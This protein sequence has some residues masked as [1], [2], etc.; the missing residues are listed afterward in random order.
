MKSK[1]WKATALVGLVLATPHGLAVAQES[2]ARAAEEAQKAE[3]LA[4]REREL[5]REIEREAAR[6][7]REAEGARVDV[8]VEMREAESRL[9]EA[10]RRVAALSTERLR[11]GRWATSFGNRP[12]LGVNIDS[13][14]SSDEP[15]AGVQI[16]SVSPGGAAAEAG[17]RGG[18]TMTAINGEPLSA[19]SGKAA[20]ARL[21]EFMKGVE[22]GD[23]LDVEYLRNG[24]SATV[25][26]APRSA[27]RVFTFRSGPPAMGVPDVM[28]A[29]TAPMAL[30]VAGW[31]SGNGFGSLEM[32]SLTEELGRYFGAE[33]GM[34]VVRAPKD[35][36]T[37]KLRDGDVIL[38]IDGR[39][40]RSVSHAARIL[41]SY[42]A[43]EVVEIRILRDQ[44]RQTVEVEIPDNRTGALG[45][46]A[47]PAAP[48]AVIA[49][50]VVIDSLVE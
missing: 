44:R 15:V 47:A 16:T 41:Y 7:A 1:Y 36:D 49:P 10:A 6:V 22:E 25:T 26:V 14:G 20:N 17:L 29:P 50:Q 3:E 8:E 19:D 30:G 11:G 33:E 5:Q 32:V 35:R 38:D 46:P 27:A 24:R 42:Q 40:P 21:V 18:D 2:E 13:G 34:L 37:Y 31:S 4:E 9:A 12:V 28:P 48:A 39:E 23:E 45:A 43:G